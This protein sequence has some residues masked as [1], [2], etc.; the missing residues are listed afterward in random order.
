MI[1]KKRIILV[2]SLVIFILLL[3]LFRVDYY[4]FYKTNKD[5]VTN[6]I[7]SEDCI[8]LYP[9]EGKIKIIFIP[10]YSYISDN[11]FENF[12]QDIKTLI[13]EDR[14]NQ[15]LFSIDIINENKDKFDFYYFN[16]IPKGARCK[17]GN[18]EEGL[19]W[20][21]PESIKFRDQTSCAEAI[22][23]IMKTCQ[24]EQAVIL[25]KVPVGGYSG[26]FDDEKIKGIMHIDVSFGRKNIVPNYYFV[27]RQSFSYPLR[28]FSSREDAIKDNSITFVHELSH[29]VFRLADMYKGGIIIEDTK[30]FQRTNTLFGCSSE[31]CSNW[32]EEYDKEKT[33]DIISNMDNNKIDMT[34]INTGI[35]CK[36]NSGCYVGCY[37]SYKNLWRPYVDGL[38]E[39]DTCDV[40]FSGGNCVNINKSI[41]YNPIQEDFVKNF[42][43]N[44]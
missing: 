10:E 37:G 15:G 29:T 12:V 20:L 2:I 35:N 39:R 13:D 36:N 34:E 31:G 9:S 41:S 44:L 5:A 14:N 1:R 19:Y 23:K 27:S 7:N 40:M 6:T 17:N 43:N 4:L 30:E 26:Y 25:Y 32:C 33:N 18:S 22:H 11:T 8:E 42:F 16:K 38:L 24:V 21:L 28:A 3:Y